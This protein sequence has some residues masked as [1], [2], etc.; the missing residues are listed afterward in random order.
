MRLEFFY[1]F[2]FANKS[3]C[4]SKSLSLADLELRLHDS[5]RAKQG[6]DPLADPSARSQFRA[7]CYRQISAR[8]GHAVAKA[9]VMRLLDSSCACFRSSGAAYTKLPLHLFPPFFC[10][11]LLSLCSS[12]LSSPFCARC[13]FPLFPLS[14]IGLR[15]FLINEFSYVSHLQT[16][17]QTK[18][19]MPFSTDILAVV[20]CHLDSVHQLA[21]LCGVNKATSPQTPA[22]RRKAWACTTISHTRAKMLPLCLRNHCR[23]VPTTPCQRYV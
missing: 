6:L 1:F 17:L 8:L 2:S 4:C 10:F 20:A 13:S 12:C 19:S 3:Y 11:P 21:M 23:L 14:V 16:N 5:L 9:L 18:K 22:D 7:M 15:S